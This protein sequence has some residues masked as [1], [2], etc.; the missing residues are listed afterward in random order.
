MKTTKTCLIVHEHSWNCAVLR[1][2][3]KVDRTKI[4]RSIYRETILRSR[5]CY[6]EQTATE[7]GIS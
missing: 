2:C 6:D 7:T 5:S 3:L 4:C 1:R